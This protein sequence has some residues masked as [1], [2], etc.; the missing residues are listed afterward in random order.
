MKKIIDW[1]FSI[2]PYHFFFQDLPKE[3]IRIY[4]KNLKDFSF[5]IFNHFIDSF[6]NHLHD[7]FHFIHNYNSVLLKSALNVQLKK[8]QTLI[9]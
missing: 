1:C 7:I 2:F 3:M 5:Y 6:V 8:T 4:C 9:A